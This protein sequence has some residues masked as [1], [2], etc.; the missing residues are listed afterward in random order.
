MMGC[1]NNS[2]FF[3]FF[4]W[5]KFVLWFGDCMV[6]LFSSFFPECVAKGICF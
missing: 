5:G 2:V 4:G 3:S 6:F 1:D